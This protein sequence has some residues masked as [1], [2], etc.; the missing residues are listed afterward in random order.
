MKT[1]Q[2]K[3]LKFYLLEYLKI[4]LHTLVR[5][6]TT[7]AR[8]APRRRAADLSNPSRRNGK[9]FLNESLKKKY[10]VVNF[11]ENNWE[12]CRPKKMKNPS[13]FINKKKI[14]KK[15]RDSLFF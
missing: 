10:Y 3:L 1:F 2:Q 12:Y 13:Y 8:K 5:G 6:L 14:K 9:L 4:S 15:E 7:E 11:F